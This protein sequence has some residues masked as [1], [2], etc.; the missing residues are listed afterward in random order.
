MELS[1]RPFIEIEKLIKLS[2]YKTL[3]FVVRRKTEFFTF[4]VI[5]S[6]ALRHIR[7][8]LMLF[9]WYDFWK[10]NN[11]VKRFNAPPEHFVFP[12]LCV[13]SF[14]RSLT[15]A[16]SISTKEVYETETFVVTWRNFYWLN[17]KCWFH[18]H[19]MK[20]FD[21]CGSLSLNFLTGDST[22]TITFFQIKV[23][24][25]M[26]VRLLINSVSDGLCLSFNSLID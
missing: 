24:S 23:P 9:S 16:D 18:V 14:G 7:S 4:Q 20:L 10:C 25:K 12:E 8:I 2:K 3:A 5:D 26:W 21:R 13:W 1:T 6:C 22:T 11:N 15:R 17:P 19:G